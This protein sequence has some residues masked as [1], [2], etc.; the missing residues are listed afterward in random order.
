M[1]TLLPVVSRWSRHAEKVQAPPWDICCNG[2]SD[3]SGSVRRFLGYLGPLYTTGRVL[4]VGE[5]HSTEFFTGPIRRL[6]QDMR[7]ALISPWHNRAEYVRRVQ[8]AH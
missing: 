2:D 5:V 4:F 1:K 7:R 6:E 3:P 8:E